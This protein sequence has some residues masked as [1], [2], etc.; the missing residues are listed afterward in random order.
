MLVLGDGESG[1]P[2][3]PAA[4]VVVGGSGNGRGGMRLVVVEL[5]V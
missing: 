4:M 2:A 3:I 5:V 1:G